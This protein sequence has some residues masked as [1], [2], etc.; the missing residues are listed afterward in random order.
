MST[1][2]VTGLTRSE[3]I[4]IELLLKSYF[5]K[6]GIGTMLSPHYA[7][8]ARTIYKKTTA[9]AQQILNDWNSK[10]LNRV[11]LVVIAKDVCNKSLV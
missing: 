1:D 3:E 2:P 4:M 11:H 8:Y 7:S 9:E 10:G 5:S 6:N